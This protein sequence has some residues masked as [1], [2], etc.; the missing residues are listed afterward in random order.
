M[1]YLGES[2]ARLQLEQFMVDLEAGLPPGER[3]R[4]HVDAKEETGRRDDAGQ[5]TAGPADLD[6]VARQLWPAIACMSNTPG[7]GTVVVGVGDDGTRTGVTVEPEDLRH[8]IWQLSGRVVTPTTE[9]RHLSDGTKLLLM[10]VAPALEPNRVDGVIKWRVRDNCVEIDAASWH[11]AAGRPAA[12]D[13][14]GEVSTATVDDVSPL[15]V[16]QVRNFLDESGRT[17]QH[18]GR[19]DAAL[20]RSLTAV[21]ADD[22]GHLTNA[23][24][25][26]L[27]SIDP[28][29][30]YLHRAGAGQD[31]SARLRH[32]GPLLGQLAEV[33]AHIRARLRTV[34]VTVPGS[35]ALT[36]MQ[37]LP[38]GAAK[39]AIANALIHR[40]WSVDQPTVIEHVDARLTVTSPGSFVG[41]V[42]ESNVLTHTS[43][44]RNPAMAAAA[45][46]CGIAEQAGSGVDR[47]YRELLQLGRPAPD[48]HQPDGASVRA[49][50]YGGDP[51]ELWVVLH[52]QLEPA[53]VRRDLR[54]LLALD[55]VAQR[56][57]LTLEMLAARIQDTTQ[58][59]ADVMEALM[60]T[61][62]DGEP[63]VKEVR[64]RPD[65]SGRAWCA[66]AHLKNAL[67]HRLP[68]LDREGRLELLTNYARET[69]RISTTEA[70]EF[71]G[72]STGQLSSDLRLLEE[73]GLVVPGTE[74][75]TG[76]GYHY[77]PVRST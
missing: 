46:A 5:V 73:Q 15:T 68:P 67:P 43:V 56:R 44:S 61:T 11:T 7:G 3:E 12:V 9:I 65:S 8:R 37:T 74:A 22:E 16:A 23:G 53:D 2:E 13:W 55:L 31:I 1:S 76:R 17:E 33:L 10:G 54:I 48:I 30:D 20:L 72:V 57:F 60:V 27:T 77:V 42:N 18:E 36:R 41:T 70:A 39:E 47:M 34:E 66:T 50:L 75:D 58:E 40:D 19:T 25:L 45:R 63:L 24:R 38:Y 35:A 4:R 21:V 32:A 52:R 51:D 69:G 59:A 28:A 6:T 26:L 14:S 64:G 29:L 49:R 71:A 62:H